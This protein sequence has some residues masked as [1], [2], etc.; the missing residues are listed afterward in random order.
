L[1]ASACGKISFDF[2]TMEDSGAPPIELDVS[3]MAMGDAIELRPEGK[4]LKDGVVIT[5]SS[6]KHVLV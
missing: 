2:H 4:A 1:A 3:Q 6:S 5:S